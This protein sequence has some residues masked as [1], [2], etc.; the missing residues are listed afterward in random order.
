MV[1]EPLF[2]LVSF[3][4]HYHSPI[5]VLPGQ[6][7][8]CAMKEWSTVDRPVAAVRWRFFVARSKIQAE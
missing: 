6:P 8:S 7:Y 5:D 1:R 4:D 2:L 3:Q